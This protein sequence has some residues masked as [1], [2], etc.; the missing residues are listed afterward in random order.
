MFDEIMELKSPEL[1]NDTLYKYQTL[2]RRLKDFKSKIFVSEIDL[3]LITKLDSYLKNLDIGD[4]G[5]FNHHK[6]LKCIINE[7]NRFK[8]AKID[9]PYTAGLFVVKSQK[10]KE[11]FLD[12]DE[13]LQIA[14]YKSS[15]VISQTCK[16]SAKSG[17]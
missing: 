2:R 10:H 6:C 14:N 3:S 11:V 4:G 13:V 12:E 5:F 16:S 17:H 8:K 9:S 1:S 15:N 7:A